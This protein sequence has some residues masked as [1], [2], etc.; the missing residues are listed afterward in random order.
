MGGW[1]VPF[2]D[3]DFGGVVSGWF[4]E[5]DEIFFGRATC[6]MMQTFW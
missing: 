1:V 4:A 2:V 5:T 3:R 6:D